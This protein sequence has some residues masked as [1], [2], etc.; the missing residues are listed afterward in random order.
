MNFNYKEKVKRKAFIAK[1]KH[2]NRV[3]KE[4]NVIVVPNNKKKSRDYYENPS[5]SYIMD[6]L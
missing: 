4:E 6:E 1:P 5:L 2:Q 3:P